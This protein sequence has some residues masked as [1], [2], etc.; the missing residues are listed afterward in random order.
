MLNTIMHHVITYL[1][2]VIFQNI[3]TSHQHFASYSK[4]TIQLQQ[5]SNIDLNIALTTTKQQQCSNSD[6]NIAICPGYNLN[7]LSIQLAL[8]DHGIVP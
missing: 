5:C 2:L 4:T 6:L 3:R 7:V 8:H 1:Q